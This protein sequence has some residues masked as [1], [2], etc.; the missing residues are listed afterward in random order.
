MKKNRKKRGLLLLMVAGLALMSFWALRTPAQAQA[1]EAELL[2]GVVTFFPADAKIKVDWVMPPIDPA[3]L[4]KYRGQI[5]FSVDDDGTPV[6]GLGNRLLLN[7][8]KEYRGVLSEPFRNFFHVGGNLLLFSTDEDFGFIAPVTRPI[9]DPETG[10]PVFPYQPLA[11]MPESE[12]GADYIVTDR[13]M[14]RGENCLYFLVTRAYQS[15]EPGYVQDVIYCLKGE[16]LTYQETVNQSQAESSSEEGVRIFSRNTVAINGQMAYSSDSSENE[17]TET[18]KGLAQEGVSESSAKTL[19]FRPI[20]VTEP[21]SLEAVNLN[22]ILAVTGDGNRTFFAVNDSIYELETGAPEPVLL[23]RHSENKTIEALAYSQETGLVYRTFDSVGVADRD[24]GLEFLKSAWLP[25]IFLN[26]GN[27]YL[28]LTGNAGIIRFENIGLL[29]KYNT[30]EREVVRV[31]GQRIRREGLARVVS[32]FLI[33]FFLCFLV[34]LIALVS[35]LVSDFKSLAKIFYL[36]WLLLG[37]LAL[38][39]A[40]GASLFLGYLSLMT[41]IFTIISGVIILS[42]FILAKRKKSKG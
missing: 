5:K 7:P 23:Y 20:L 31:D 18:T 42:Y 30:P 33:I 1:Q 6:I 29:Q 22:Q 41:L 19:A 9:T 26:A 21:V 16:G 10:F 35:L 25:E 13:R 12:S 17:A 39:L 24:S 34:W 27:L 14:F 38:I 3:I 8:A 11:L 32:P 15:S 28:M 4:E 36:L 40:V 37:L 2:K